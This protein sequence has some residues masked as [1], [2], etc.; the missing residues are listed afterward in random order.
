MALIGHYYSTDRQSSL[1]LG[2]KG[3]FRLPRAEIGHFLVNDYSF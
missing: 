3:A 1:T 2:Q